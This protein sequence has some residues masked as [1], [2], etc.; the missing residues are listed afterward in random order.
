MIV[1]TTKNLSKSG[2]S[3]RDRFA[4]I[5]KTVTCCEHWLDINSNPFYINILIRKAKL[6]LQ[7]SINLLTFKK[8]RGISVAI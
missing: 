7:M 2:S 6:S 3:V 4:D 8:T 1:T 5:K